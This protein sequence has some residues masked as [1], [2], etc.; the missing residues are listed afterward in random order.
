MK[1]EVRMALVDMLTTMAQVPPLERA[2]RALSAAG[3]GK[4]RADALV[5]ALRPHVPGC[6]L[7]LRWGGLSVPILGQA[8]ARWLQRERER[9]VRP[10]R[11]M[12]VPGARP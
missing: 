3:I 2:K 7:R 1:R 4:D 9:L 10:A 8:S 11:R 5:E 6:Q 12:A